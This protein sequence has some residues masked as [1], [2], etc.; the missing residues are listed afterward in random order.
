[1]H[2]HRDCMSFLS[3]LYTS[4]YG[5]TR[6]C[7]ATCT[8]RFFVWAAHHVPGLVARAG[9]GAVQA[10]ASAAAAARWALLPFP[11]PLLRLPLLLPFTFAFA[12]SFS[13]FFPCSSF[14][15]ALFL[16]L[17]SALSFT[18]VYC[19]LVNWA[20]MLAFST[21]CK[22]VEITKVFP[23]ATYT[24]VLIRNVGVRPALAGEWCSGHNGQAGSRA[25]G[26]ASSWGGFYCIS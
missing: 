9:A 6:T 16:L 4:G 1:M 25:Y 10:A 19:F 12:L 22:F 8:D 14:C 23:G 24:V 21:V 5:L 13:F 18:F 17:L 7:S 3:M 20:R 2:I 26:V 15:F 11:M